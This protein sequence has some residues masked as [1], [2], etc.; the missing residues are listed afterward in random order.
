MAEIN[1]PDMSNLW[2]SGGAVVAPSAAKIETGW[3]AEIPPH[4]YQNWHQNRSDQAISYLFQ[5]GVAQWDGTTEYFA[6][7]SVVQHNGQ[8]Y[9]AV[10]NSVN[11]NPTSNLA[12]WRPIIVS[13]T[14]TQAGYIQIAT[15]TEVGAATNDT[16]AVTP[17]KLGQFFTTRFVQATESVLGVAKIATQA[18]TNTGTDDATIVTPKKLRFGIAMSLG[19]TGYITL[20]SWLG[21]VT[22]QWG[23]GSMPLTTL[24]GVYYTGTATLNL[25]VPLTGNPY[26]CI[27][28]IQKTPNALNT[29][30]SSGWSTTQVH[31]SGATSNESPQTPALYYFVVGK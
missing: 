31:F 20:P 26:V 19:S 30:S 13:A 14:E 2:A 3:T 24:I 23:S 17:L 10:T 18:Q 21:G 12:Y 8:L 9:F 25:P 6:T 29:I 22:F 4:Q 15:S 27:P 7:K 1:K 11:Q 28:V 16:K 5:R